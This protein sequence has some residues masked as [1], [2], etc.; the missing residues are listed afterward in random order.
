M[1]WKNRDIN[2][3]EQANISQFSK[4]DDTGTLLRLF[5]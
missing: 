3:E 2:I 1:K 4:L 5:E